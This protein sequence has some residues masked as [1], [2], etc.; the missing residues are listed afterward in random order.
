M[1]QLAVCL[2][3]MVALATGFAH[4]EDSLCPQINTVATALPQTSPEAAEGAIALEQGDVVFV[5]VC[6]LH[7]QAIYS[8]CL[9][10]CGGTPG[11]KVD[12]KEDYQACCLAGGGDPWPY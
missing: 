8:E 9:N 11:C 4:A 3:L 1:K 5:V 2:V 7:C 12:C 10:A 6:P